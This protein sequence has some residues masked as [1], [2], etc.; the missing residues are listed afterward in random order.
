MLLS[1]LLLPYAG[2]LAE[3]I[4]HAYITGQSTPWI[5]RQ[6]TVFAATR[7]KK[8]AIKR[9]EGFLAVE[10]SREEAELF[11]RELEAMLETM[12]LSGTMLAEQDF[13]TEK[14]L[15]KIWNT[16]PPNIEIFQ[17]GL[18]S[19]L[20]TIIGATVTTLAQLIQE[21]QQWEQVAWNRVFQLLDKIRHDHDQQ[22][23][24]LHQISST[25]HVLLC[26]RQKFP[27]PKPIIPL[28]QRYLP[29][30]V[31]PRQHDLMNIH[32][33]LDKGEDLLAV[34]NA[35]KRII[36]LADAGMGK[37]WELERMA[38]ELSEENNA[39]YPLLDNQLRSYSPADPL[40][41]RVR[42]LWPYWD[43]I[44]D[45]RRVILLDGLDEVGDDNVTATVKRF[46]EFAEEHPDSTILISCRTKVFM[47]FS[48]FLNNFAPYYLR[49]LNGQE[50]ETY[51]RNFIGNKWEDFSSKA[52][53]LKLWDLLRVPF[54]LAVATELYQQK[55]TLPSRRAAFFSEIIESRLS[56]DS[57]RA[58]ESGTLKSRQKLV[59][60]LLS[61]IA[62]GMEMLCTNEIT[63]TLLLRLIP[64]QTH[65][66]IL[67]MTGIWNSV[68]RNGEIFWRF[69]HN[70]IQEALAGRLLATM[71]FDLIKACI[72]VPP[73]FSIVNP[74]FGNAVS[75]ML[76][77]TSDNEAM[78][79]LATVAPE[80]VVQ[81]E[82][83]LMP[84]ENRVVFVKGILEDFKKRGAT[85]VWSKF[86]ADDLARFADSP[87]LLAWL[88]KEAA[89]ETDL[90]HFASLI[91]VAQCVTVPPEMADQVRSFYLSLFK[92]GKRPPWIQRAGINALSHSRLGNHHVIEEIIRDTRGFNDAEF[93]MEVYRL[94]R[95]S[96]CVDAFIGDILNGIEFS[97]GQGRLLNER[98][99][100]REAISEVVSSHALIRVCDHFAMK[101]ERVEELFLSHDFGDFI[102][103]AV[104]IYRAHP[105]DAIFEAVIRLYIGLCRQGQNQFIASVTQ[106]FVETTTQQTAVECILVARSNDELSVGGAIAGLATRTLLENLI[107]RCKNKGIEKRIIE[108]I[109]YRLPQGELRD[110]FGKQLAEMDPDTFMQKQRPTCTVLTPQQDF[111]LLFNQEAYLH[112]LEAIFD[113]AG[114][115]ALD[116]H[117]MHELR[118]AP[119]KNMTLSSMIV[120]ELSRNAAKTPVS[121]NAFIEKVRK[122]WNK[123]STSTAAEALVEKSNIKL[124][125]QKYEIF[126]HWCKGLIPTVSFVG[127]N[128]TRGGTEYQVLAQCI[129]SLA[130]VMDLPLSPS[131]CSQFLGFPFSALPERVQGLVIPY[132]SRHLGATALHREIVCTIESGQVAESVLEERYRYC[133]EQKVLEV[134]PVAKR[135]LTN[136]ALS[137]DLRRAALLALE[138]IPGGRDGIVAILP[139]LHGDLL[140]AALDYLSKTMEPNAATYL[141]NLFH[142]EKG[143]AQDRAAHLLI[144]YEDQKAIRYYVGR[145]IE[146]GHIPFEDRVDRPS[147]FASLVKADSITP[148]LDLLKADYKGKTIALT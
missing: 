20:K 130:V 92:D 123:W 146:L 22:T 140:L 75:F 88:V 70:S 126:E 78:E 12:H 10:M 98:T 39:H 134:I 62:L 87:D 132:L 106:F 111:D 120:D 90:R 30:R 55:G 81:S 95:T 31:S 3:K 11:V 76:E 14:I 74:S 57:N 23:E 91:R 54:Y 145:I 121:R 86:E 18:D 105:E 1:S 46:K 17:R 9:L 24:L 122:R 80:I 61:R 82:N 117:T 147:V 53:I 144:R 56:K 139:E 41:D 79:W 48:D 142:A 93:L 116:W 129:I 60:E 37:S 100:I 7:I 26:D 133:G 38:H 97:L 85:I 99:E 118:W 136:T 125:P 102:R 64:D 65:R 4:V 19:K 72:G 135:D 138:E 110:W 96:K 51:V 58:A 44:P 6:M 73:L 35:K 25:V 28:P 112:Q 40:V 119:K 108:G 89:C 47:P 103:N 45:S 127:K 34:M 109:L 15:C 13:N 137:P 21:V 63:D 131:E 128:N 101:P 42:R 94:I 59:L 141:Q 33:F 104:A 107:Q 2:K 143:V 67:N 114:V 16:R 83:S 66:D 29:R 43:A 69:E 36:L 50:M 5:K 115:D 68:A 49:Y 77:E 84:I 71:R 52:S 113:Q 148:L 8:Q 27:P 124:T 32:D